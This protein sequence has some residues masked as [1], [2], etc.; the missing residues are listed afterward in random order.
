MSL[1][2]NAAAIHGDQRFDDPLNPVPFR[3]LE[4]KYKTTGTKRSR[5]S[6][7]AVIVEILTRE[8]LDEMKDTGRIRR[9]EPNNSECS[10]L[11]QKARNDEIFEFGSGL[12][13]PKLLF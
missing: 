13:A 8:I 6:L 1:T 10:R 11:F 5:G 12:R 7:K 4:Q 9:F 2:I 3:F